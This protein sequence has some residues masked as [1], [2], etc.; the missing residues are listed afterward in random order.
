MARPLQPF[1]VA[2]DGRV[3][4]RQAGHSIGRVVLDRDDGWTGYDV[5]GDKITDRPHWNGRKYAARAVWDAYL[6]RTSGA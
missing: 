4:H 1:K 5:V 3:I 2:Q 6:A